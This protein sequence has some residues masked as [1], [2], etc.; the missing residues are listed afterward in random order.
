M[1]TRS[2][3]FRPAAGAPGQDRL[4]VGLRDAAAS[5]NWRRHLA[6]SA[7]DATAAH[8]LDRAQVW[9]DPA[10]VRGLGP[11]G[12]LR[13]CYDVRALMADRLF[14]YVQQAGPSPGQEA[15]A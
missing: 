3:A 6:L 7:P 2:C 9:V 5:P 14:A 4:R 1:R 12:S 11:L 10:H 8:V 15:H 13:A